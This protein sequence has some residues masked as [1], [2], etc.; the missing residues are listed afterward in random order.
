MIPYVTKEQ[1][2]KLD[3]LMV[4]FYH[5]PV[6]MMMENAGY[7]MAEFLRSNFSGKNILICCGKGNN[8]GNGISAARHLLN[9][10]Y[11]P[12]IFLASKKISKDASRYLKVAKKLRIPIIYTEKDLKSALKTAAAIYDCLIGYNLEGEPIGKF[13]TVIKLLNNS[14]KKIIAC[15]VPSGVDTDK[16]PIYKVWC[17]PTYILFLSLPKIGSKKI[18]AKKF[19]ADIGVPLD[20]YK[21][22]RVKPKNYFEKEQIVPLKSFL[23]VLPAST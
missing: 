2:S 5:I 16:G 15:D 19:V 13:K 18:S 22:I 11:K 7:R 12:T 8:G 20:L 23:G 4:N 1:I 6:V 10:G 21:K 9:F 14:N 3:D 17:K